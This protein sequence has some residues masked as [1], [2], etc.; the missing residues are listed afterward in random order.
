[1]IMNRKILSILLCIC[2]IAS[3][4]P[5]GVS[6][7]VLAAENEHTNEEVEE[8]WVTTEELG[9]KYGVLKTLGIHSDEFNN[10]LDKE[11]TKGE[12]ARVIYA[13]LNCYDTYSD[14]VTYSDIAEEDRQMY[15]ALIK[16]GIITAKNSYMIAPDETISYND[17]ARAIVT[18]LGYD[19]FAKHYGGYVGAY[20]AVCRKASALYA[21]STVTYS[22]LMD[23]VYDALFIPPAFD[24]LLEN[25]QSSVSSTHLYINFKM[26]LVSGTLTAVPFINL[27]SGEAFEDD[28]IIV[29]GI[30]YDCGIEATKYL[31]TD[32][33]CLVKDNGHS[34]DYDTAIGIYPKNSRNDNIAVLEAENIISY[35]NNLYKYDD[36]NRTRE[37]SLDLRK[38][39]IYNGAILDSY[40]ATDLIPKCGTVELID[41]DRNSVYE[42]VNIREYQTMYV[43]YVDTFNGVITD[44]DYTVPSLHFK[45]AQKITVTQ[46]GEP[47]NISSISSGSVI[48][49]YVS[50]DSSVLNIE[51]TKQSKSGV[52]TYVSSDKNTIRIDDVEYGV[53]RPYFN[54]YE[55][56]VKAGSNVTAYINPDGKISLI[57]KA[58]GAAMQTGYLINALIDTKT[59][60]FNASLVL[61]IFETS[62]ELKP[63]ITTEKVFV[64]EV[65]RDINAAYNDLK[66]GTSDIFSQPVRY[67]VNDDG[68][69]TRIDT[70][71]NNQPNEVNG[72]I[73]NKR[74]TNGVEETDSFRLIYSG[75]LNPEAVPIVYTAGYSLHTFGDPPLFS[76]K[77]SATVF[78][79]PSNPKTA[80][81][82]YYRA[83][84]I[85]GYFTPN[86]KY[87]VDAY[88]FGSNSRVAD[89]VV[90]VDN[91]SAV[92]NQKLSSNFHMG[93]VQSVC[94]EL[95]DDEIVTSVFLVGD[96]T[97]TKG[98]YFDPKKFESPIRIKAHMASYMTDE[99]LQN[100][101]YSVDEGD[102]IIFDLD[103]A[104]YI[105]NAYL[106]YDCDDTD[107]NSAFK[108]G[109]NR[110]YGQM[111]ATNV[112][113]GDVVDLE[114]TIVVT[115]KTNLATYTGNIDDLQ[116]M[117]QPSVSGS[118]ARVTIG[119]RGKFVERTGTNELPKTYRSHGKGRSQ[120]ISW[121]ASGYTKFSWIINRED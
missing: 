74:P 16:R 57:T 82:K 23:Y 113:Y 89:L 36:N 46:S 63:Y 54:K 47:K 7:T 58:S 69:I 67:A 30:K 98:Y 37:Y 92:G 27:K 112:N 25:Y 121:T 117:V 20:N 103:S 9:Y 34:S 45:D 108:M 102:I 48:K 6:S 86:T 35:N 118:T 114:D 94:E 56:L 115:T 83:G 17:V 119:K 88:S 28:R 106:V 12:F 85:Q 55:S 100:E 62:G 84:N 109:Y 61:Q 43:S 15:T 33:F 42:Y 66:R 14:L 11:V 26:K 8:K 87:T 2:L 97:S 80:D 5:F 99:N 3:Y 31:G 107:P 22:Q 19:V 13:F 120:L 72:T 77:T 38:M 101:F 18:I 70:A 64:D 78:G 90:V 110:E 79:M 40:T 76:V 93:M 91:S 105:T 52:I 75:Y 65:R 44:K 116:L 53:D 21:T 51:Y 1:M 4:I 41:S 71:Y 104:D 111:I 50:K 96:T 95:V 32:V 10:Q 60:P 49:A 39:V 24:R 81:K 68:K 73:Y 29:G 59:D